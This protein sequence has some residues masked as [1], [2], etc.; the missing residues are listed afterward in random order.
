MFNPKKEA[1]NIIDFIKKYYKNNKLGGVVIGI[2]GGKDS[3]VVAGLFSKALGGE[4]VIGVTMPCHSNSE[5]R[6]DAK[7]VAEHFNFKLINLDLTT[8]F[9]TFT[10]EA[11]KL[12]DYVSS[13]DANIN[14]KPRLRMTTLYYLAQMYTKKTGKVYI[15]AGTGNK[16][17][18]FVGYFTKGGDSVSDIKVISDLCVDEVIK[19]GEVIGVPEKVLYKPPS[20]GLSGKTD[21]DKLGFTYADVKKVINN[22]EINEDIKDRI[23]K[24]HNA[25]KH[26]FSIPT[27]KRYE[28]LGI[29]VGSFNP[30][31]D[32]HIHVAKHILKENLVDKVLLLPTPNYWD[33]TDLVPVE[34]RINM[35]NY[36]KEENIIVDTIHNNHE[37]TY[38]VLN[39]LK[40]DY[41]NAELYLIIGSDNVEKF[42]LWKNIDELLKYKIIVLNR[43]DKDIEKTLAKFNSNNFIVLNNFKFINVS[44][45]EIRQG[46]SEHVKKEVLDYIKNHNL[47]NKEK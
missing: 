18:E 43:G 24:K 41:P 2:S 22:E 19:V 25:N 17:E 39:S 15:V 46:K 10:K 6:E 42:H 21:E 23:I 9:D 44:S 30:V 29:Y 14:I 11:E 7:L 27:Y 12:D 32:G 40:E 47:Y 36:Y 20:D 31:H 13:E 26:K 4:N 33:K 8:V 35:L 38:Q 1:K 28:R 16:S 5:D 45:T 34:D 3:A 37:F